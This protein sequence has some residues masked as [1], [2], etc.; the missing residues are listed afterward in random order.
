MKKITYLLI[1]LL[2]PLSFAAAVMPPGSEINYIYLLPFIPGTGA[3]CGSPTAPFFYIN[4]G[5][6]KISVIWLIGIIIFWVLIKKTL[7]LKKK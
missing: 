5:F 2:T 6:G 4:L 1:L 7:G 3:S